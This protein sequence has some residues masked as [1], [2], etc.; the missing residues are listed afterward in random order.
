MVS[1]HGW[2]QCVNIVTIETTAANVEVTEPAEIEQ[3]ERWR[4]APAYSS[5]SLT[6]LL[7]LDAAATAQ[8]KSNR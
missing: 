4:H 1:L 8:N 6:S 3:Y 5:T 2:E 7:L